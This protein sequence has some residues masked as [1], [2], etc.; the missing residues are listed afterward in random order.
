M[1]KILS[2][3][4]VFVENFVNILKAICFKA[5][6]FFI[7]ATCTKFYSPGTNSPMLRTICD[8]GICECAEGIK[9]YN[10]FNCRSLTFQFYSYFKAVIKFILNNSF[11]TVFFNAFILFPLNV[12]SSHCSYR[13]IFQSYAF[14]MTTK[15]S[16]IKM[17]K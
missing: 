7:D 1:A 16:I 12:Y 10:F 6:F 8:G 17:H 15:Q 11:I 4:H 3:E 5:C 2:S 9:I 13:N 14:R